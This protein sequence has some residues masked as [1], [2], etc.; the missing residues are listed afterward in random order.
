VFKEGVSNLQNAVFSST[1]AY[2][3]EIQRQSQSLNETY[4]SGKP[5]L[6]F[7]RNQRV[8]TSHWMQLFDRHNRSK[9]AR[10]E[11]TNSMVTDVQSEYRHIQRGIAST[12][13][14]I[15]GF[16]GQ[17]ASEVGNSKFICVYRFFF[18][19]IASQ[20]TGLSNVT[21]TYHKAANTD[22]SLIQQSTKSLMEQGT[23]EDTGTGL[24]PKN[25]YG[26]MLMSGS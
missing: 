24:T 7:F 19:A 1:A 8:M 5:S 14:N 2:S 16:A 4:I 10:I 23:R 20:T 25:V 26:N 13:R 17:V 11:A 18:D 9:R 12:S 21:T 22:L 3:S 6:F 15:E